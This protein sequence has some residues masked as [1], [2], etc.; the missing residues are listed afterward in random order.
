M[1]TLAD[2]VTKRDEFTVYGEHIANKMRNCGRSKLEVAKAQH[3][4]DD[5]CYRLTV[6]EFLKHPS[7]T[8]YCESAQSS[9]LSPIHLYP[10]VMG[11]PP[12]ST[13][14]PVNFNQ[15]LQYPP[16][17]ILSA[18]TSRSTSTPSSPSGNTSEAFALSHESL[19]HPGT[20]QTENPMQENVRTFFSALRG[21][22]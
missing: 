3:L 17:P 20:P 2:S 13:S 10:A 12:Q 1:K 7:Q 11:V 8:S 19:P 16:V 14:S 15:P 9:S 6:G 22:Y 4:I 5:V 21:E 18:A